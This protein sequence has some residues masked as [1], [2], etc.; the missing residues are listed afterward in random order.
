M[1]GSMF[2][3]LGS[4]GRPD[5]LHDSGMWLP[6]NHR[7]AVF[8]ARRRIPRIVSTRGMLEP[9]ALHHKKFKK[10]IAWWLYQQSDLRRASLLH[11]SADQE[12]RN[13]QQLDLDVPTCMIPNGVDLPMISTQS[14]QP[15]DRA[16]FRTA[17][18]VGRIY[19]VKGLPMLIEAW[20]QVRPQG[21]CLHIAGPDEA[22]HR[23]EVE[24]A[25]SRSG[26][27]DTVSFLGPVDGENKS[28]VYAGAD[29]FVLSSYSES[30]G[31]VVGEA[32]A[33]GIPVLTTR[34]VPW[35]QLAERGC[36]W[37]VD[38][39]VEGLIQGLKVA[40]SQPPATLRAMGTRGRAWVATEFGWNA[41][42]KQFLGVYEQLV[43][44]V[45]L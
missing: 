17:L 6:H 15:T 43:A 4:F 26:L 41:I 20:G 2:D 40:T 9:W 19:P 16:G 30:F 5:V 29:L 11:T 18:F 23:A 36:G 25:V 10:T 45:N 34:G 37:S 27:S 13:L 3:A 44:G 42:A 7:L 35:P 22:G 38:T 31:I 21:W 39:T 12:W 24:R 33:H 28:A 8:A 32:L 14:I 1:R